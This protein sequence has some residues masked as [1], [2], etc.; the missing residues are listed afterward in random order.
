LMQNDLRSRVRLEADGKLMSG[1]DIAIAC[2]L[3][4]EEFGFSTTALVS[5]GCVM[6]RV[7]NLDTCPVGI[8]TQNPE[9]RKRFSGKPEY[10][11]NLMRFMAQDLREH[12]ARLGIRTVDELVGRTDLLR[13][14]EKAVSRRAELVDLSKILDNPFAGAGAKTHFDPAD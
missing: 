5:M 3:G 1:R 12:M 13:Q 4:A 10:V 14:R 6:M 7:C 8:A 9:L 2:M 11:I